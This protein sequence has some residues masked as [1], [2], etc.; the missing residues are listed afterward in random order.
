MREEIRELQRQANVTTVFVTHDQ[1]EALSV[2]D[3]IVV[4]RAGYI[5]QMDSPEAVYS[6]PATCFVADFMGE[7]NIVEGVPSIDGGQTHLVHKSGVRLPMAEMEAQSG[8]SATIG[9]RPE[10]IRIG[11]LADDSQGIQ[12][13]VEDITYR[14]AFSMVRC[15]VSPSLELRAIRMN[16]S[17]TVEPFAVGDTV[18][19]AW[20]ANAARAI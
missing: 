16:T 5:E 3:R 4:M 20:P 11:H 10:A 8:A 19:L 18:R 1:D 6:R 17:E 14:G 12:A 15:R 7:A 2:S 9:I 13:I